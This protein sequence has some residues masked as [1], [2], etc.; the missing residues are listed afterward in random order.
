MSTA[1]QKPTESV[2]LNAFKQPKA[3]Y[4]IFSIELWERFGYYGLQGIMAVYLVKQLGMSEADSITLFSSFSALVYGLVAIGGWLGDKVLGTKRVIMLGAIVLAI[5][6]ALVAWSGH[7]AGIVYMGMAAIAVGNGLFKA[8]PASLLSK[9]YPPKDPRLDGA[10]TLFYMSINIGSLIALSLAPVIA[11]RFGYS[12]TYNLCGAGLIIALLV[13][14]ACR[15]MVKDIGSEPDFRPMSFSKL[16][17]V[18]LGSVVMIFVCAWLMHNVEV[19]NLVLIV[20]SIVV[21]II[22]FR[23]AFKLDK[24]GRN[25]MFV[26]F[27][28]MLEAVVF[29]ILYAQMPTSL[30]FFAIN[31]VH[32]EILGFSINP[33]SFQ[34]LNPFWVVLAS[35]I[36]AGIYTHLGNK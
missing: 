17:Y 25:K 11:D 31:N 6:Y 33:V 36:L 29:Y 20:L 10:F 1:N 2:S 26:A 35:P 8:N 18:L 13:Y 4:L 27:V 7:D 34:A 21:T 9:C 16:L 15:G 12:V 23:Q 22:F 3:F 30:N 14:I 32:H 24:T 19:A 28:L 5:G